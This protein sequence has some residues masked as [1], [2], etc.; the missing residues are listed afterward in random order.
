MVLL[1]KTDGN[2][3]HLTARGQSM[4]LEDMRSKKTEL[5]LTNEMI[6]QTSGIPL[7]TIQKVFSGTT[8]APRKSTLIAIETVLFT[9]ESRRR[10]LAVYQYVK[11]GADTRN[12]SEKNMPYFLESQEPC[13]FKE[14]DAA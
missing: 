8:R 3:R 11:N 12:G 14:A 2:N 5:G 13:S 7:S 4:T 9:E 10:E 6:A 1:R